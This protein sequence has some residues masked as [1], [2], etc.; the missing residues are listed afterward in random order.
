MKKSQI[1]AVCFACIA[2]V[3]Y[4][5]QDKEE[6]SVAVSNEPASSIEIVL[7]N[8]MNQLV[9][10]TIKSSCSTEMECLNA[11][12]SMSSKDYQKLYGTLPVHV[13]ILSLECSESCKIDFSQEI[14]EFEPSRQQEVEQVVAYLL[15]NYPD[16]EITVEGKAVSLFKTDT[17]HYLNTAYFL[18]EDYHRG[19]LYQMYM[20]EEIQDQ[21]VAVPVV[22]YSKEMNPL[23]AIEAYYGASASVQ[24]DNMH[25]QHVEIVDENPLIVRLSAECM[26]NQQLNDALVLPILY[27]LKK[28]TDAS[29]VWIEVDGVIVREVALNDVRIN[30]F[31][32]SE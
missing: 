3:L 19:R 13:S 8:E 32:L 1:A 28:H 30:D 15:K 25:Y 17:D 14:L 24:F 5:T 2:L 27:S 12:F 6:S 9:P 21:N 11:S 18:D 4:F 26:M 29:N 22:V 20:T 23:K 16:A 31:H 7:K 10:L